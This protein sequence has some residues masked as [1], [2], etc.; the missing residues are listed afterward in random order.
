MKRL[1]GAAIILSALAGAVQASDQNGR[2]NAHDGKKA[3][4]Q[5]SKDQR[6]IDLI[7]GSKLPGPTAAAR[8]HQARIQ[9]I[10]DIYQ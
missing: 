6:N 8:A 4:V 3:H 1:F 5:A 7:K 9:A 2:D 10:K